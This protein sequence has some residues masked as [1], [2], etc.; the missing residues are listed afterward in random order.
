MAPTNVDSNG[1]RGRALKQHKNEEGAKPLDITV[2]RLASKQVDATQKTANGVMGSDSSRAAENRDS[3]RAKFILPEFKVKEVH[4]DGRRATLLEVPQTNGEGDDNLPTVEIL[5]E[6]EGAG[7]SK[8]STVASSTNVGKAAG[9]TSTPVGSPT[10]GVTPSLIPRPSKSFYSTLAPSHPRPLR[11][12]A[13]YTEEE[14]RMFALFDQIAAEDES[15]AE[16]LV[17]KQHFLMKGANGY[18]EKAGEFN[19]LDDDTAFLNAGPHKSRSQEV[20]ATFSV[21]FM[22]SG[23]SLQSGRSLNAS[24]DVAHISSASPAADPTRSPAH[25]ADSGHFS[26]TGSDLDPR[27]SNASV[28]GPSSQDP[29]GKSKTK[30]RRRKKKKGGVNANGLQ[31]SELTLP[32]DPARP[33][34][35]VS[36]QPDVLTAAEMSTAP[37]RTPADVYARMNKVVNHAKTTGIWLEIEHEAQ[38]ANGT[39]ELLVSRVTPTNENSI[40]SVSTAAL[41]VASVPPAPATPP[42]TDASSYTPSSSPSVLESSNV[43]APAI[44]SLT[45]S[46]ST[47][48]TQRVAPKSIL[49]KRLK[50]ISDPNPNT[51]AFRGRN[52]RGRGR[53]KHGNHQHGPHLK[54][55]PQNH[56]PSGGQDG[57]DEAAT[58]DD[59]KDRKTVHFAKPL[60]LGPTGSETPRM[61]ALT[62]GEWRR[63]EKERKRREALAAGAESGGGGRRSSFSEGETTEASSDD[64]RRVIIVSG[65]EGFPDDENTDS[66]A[67]NETSNVAVLSN[68]VSEHPLKSIDASGV[69]HIPDGHPVPREVTSSPPPS[70]GA[71]PNHASPTRPPSRP[72]N[73]SVIEREWTREQLD[74]VVA[75]EVVDEFVSA[76][77]I[78]QEYARLER[79]IFPERYA[80]QSDQP[81]ESEDL[82]ELAPT[83]PASQTSDA[84]F[85]DGIIAWRNAQPF[86]RAWSAGGDYGN[87]GGD[88]SDVEDVTFDGGSESEADDPALEALLFG[89][90][91]DDYDEDDGDAPHTRNKP[92]STNPFSYVPPWYATET[93]RGATPQEIKKER[94]K[95][96]N[97]LRKLAA[98]AQASQL[99]QKSTNF[100]TVPVPIVADPMAPVSPASVGVGKSVSS[101]P[102]PTLTNNLEFHSP[103]E[104]ISERVNR[105]NQALVGRKTSIFKQ[106][107]G[108]HN[109][110]SDAEAPSLV[111]DSSLSSGAVIPS[112][113]DGGVA[114]GAHMPTP[115]TRQT[116]TVTLTSLAA[117]HPNVTTYQSFGAR[118]PSKTSVCTI[119]T[120]ADIA[121]HMGE[122]LK[123]RES[124]ATHVGAKGSSSRILNPSNINSAVV[125]EREITQR[126]DALTDTKQALDTTFN[127]SETTFKKISKFKQSRI[128]SS[129]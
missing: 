47:V 67:K 38:A 76:R 69:E 125:V 106:R 104:I 98:E 27:S 26:D 126:E 117:S 90:D 118:E 25:S 7:V 101:S 60:E 53:G 17:E 82:E 123:A 73:E 102:N 83:S 79:R 55:G 46:S 127:L 74:A 124:V 94:E 95:A 41:S 44:P 34:G 92:T 54:R 13:D 37:I 89:G 77:E 32:S 52:T 120:P 56:N 33:F 97:L 84:D 59:R 70:T 100:D 105:D 23:P 68:L 19:E 62:K 112:L 24:V 6:E 63:R 48:P 88:D 30:K 43:T 86:R 115:G 85:D 61:M 4:S 103:S 128:A 22:T 75:E 110:E 72:V 16:G 107:R 3:N 119:R 78:A 114:S 21:P 20:G 111:V 113:K 51:P 14:K 15:E 35:S 29:T 49:K 109:E 31:T 91:D 12:P 65:P 93:R 42:P 121:Q 39:V 64:E 8:M 129:T 122:A 11:T 58:S 28:N 71:L 66:L 96:Q 80:V 40:M 9:G 81:E 1:G 87:P 108:M 99:E 18:S 5:E 10:R 57:N 50:P 36:Q 2:R 45:D 116:D